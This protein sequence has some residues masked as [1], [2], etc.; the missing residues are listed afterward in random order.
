MM[1]GFEFRMDIKCGNMRK[2]IEFTFFERAKILF[3]NQLLIYI[4]LFFPHLNSFNCEKESKNP[5]NYN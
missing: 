5:F 2:E 3:A 1:N 4:L